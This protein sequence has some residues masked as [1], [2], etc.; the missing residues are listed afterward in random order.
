MSEDEEVFYA[1]PGAKCYIDGKRPAKIL[2]FF[3]EGSTSFSFAHYVV[4]EDG[5]DRQTVLHATRIR[6]EKKP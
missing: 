5:S 1:M 4:L 6:F 3:P 2:Q